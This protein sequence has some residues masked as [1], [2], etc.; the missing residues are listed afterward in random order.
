M[1]DAARLTLA[2]AQEID[3]G[4]GGVG[5]EIAGRGQQAQRPARGIALFF[6]IGLPIRHRREPRLGQ[7][8][9]IEFELPRR[10][11]ELLAIFRRKPDRSAAAYITQVERRRRA[12]GAAE[13]LG[14]RLGRAH[15]EHRVGQAHAPR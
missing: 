13:Q 15:P 6:R 8:L 2:P 9:R 14:Q 4:V 3:A 1:Q 5:L 7:L 11:T 10:G 12:F